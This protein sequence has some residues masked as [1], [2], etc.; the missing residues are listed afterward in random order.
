M[1]KYSGIEDKVVFISGASKGIGLSIAEAFAAQGAKIVMNARSISAEHPSVLKI[2]EIYQ[3]NGYTHTPLALAGDISDMESV[4]NMFNEIKNNPAFQTVNIGVNNAGISK[5][6]LF[7]R[8]KDEDWDSTIAI[9]LKGV[10]NCCLE[11]IKMMRKTGGAIINMSSVIG[12]HGNTGQTA[13][14]ASKAGVIALTMSLADEYARSGI[15]VNAVAPGYIKTEMT[16]NVN[17]EAKASW[18][19]KIPLKRIGEGSEVGEAVLFLASDASSYIT[20]QT[21]GVDG[22]W[23]RR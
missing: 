19:E 13:Y 7:I 5:D 20:G 22:G 21:L 2:K 3:K 4:K 14:A 23:F 11:E 17:P 15:R 16:D 10:R 12:Q 1:T 18:E 9:N 8:Q 6:G